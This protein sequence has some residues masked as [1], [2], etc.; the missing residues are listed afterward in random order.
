M[1]S[2]YND[3]IFKIQGDVIDSSHRSLNDFVCFLEQEYAIDKNNLSVFFDSENSFFLIISGASFLP[4]AVY[5]VDS[6]KLNSMRSSIYKSISDQLDDIEVLPILIDSEQFEAKELD[7]INKSYLRIHLP[8]YFKKSLDIK[9]ITIRLKQQFNNPTRN[10]FT[11]TPST[12]I[13][14]IN[15][16]L[17][18]SKTTNLLI[19]FFFAISPEN[20]PSLD[21]LKTCVILRTISATTNW[22]NEDEL[23]TLMAVCQHLDI[24]SYRWLCYKLHILNKLIHRSDKAFRNYSPRKCGIPMCNDLYAKYGCGCK[25]E[26][27]VTTPLALAFINTKTIDEFKF[28]KENGWL[29]AIQKHHRKNEALESKLQLSTAFDV[30]AEI[31]D[32]NQTHWG[33]QLFHSRTKPNT[34]EYRIVQDIIIKTDDILKNNFLKILAKYGIQIPN[35]GDPRTKQAI[36]KYIFNYA[37]VAYEAKAMK[38]IENPNEKFWTI[39]LTQKAGWNDESYASPIEKSILPNNINPNDAFEFYTPLFT[40]CFHNKFR[41]LNPYVKKGT[42]VDWKKEYLPEPVAIENLLVCG[43]SLF[44]LLL[45]K[46]NLSTCVF[47]IWG[48]NKAHRKR[49]THLASSV[50]G[51]PEKFI[52]KIDYLEE[53]FKNICLLHNDSL[54]CISEISE[55]SI[56]RYLRL[57]YQFAFE[58]LPFKTGDTTTKHVFLSSGEDPIPLPHAKKSGGHPIIINIKTDGIEPRGETSIAETPFGCL[59]T[60]LVL[61]ILFHPPPLPNPYELNYA[62]DFKKSMNSTFIKRNK[63][64]I[65]EIEKISFKILQTSMVIMEMPPTYNPGSNFTETYKIKLLDYFNQSLENRTKDEKSAV[66]SIKD[67][68]K[69]YGH[70]R[71]IN[72]NVLIA[73]RRSENNIDGFYIIIKDQMF[74]LILTECFDRL[75]C[76]YISK[77]RLAELLLEEKILKRGKNGAFSSTH[78]IK[79][80]RKSRRGYLLRLPSPP[81]TAKRIPRSKNDLAQILE[82][83]DYPLIF[84]F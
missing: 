3:L 73:D 80:L 4:Y 34:Q 75:F 45:K 47:H 30:T 40:F 44:P 53:N 21:N 32:E 56:Q 5:A 24:H 15:K 70:S 17:A 9:S 58:E 84:P 60:A 65:K 61:R 6:N 72:S 13:H 27:G 71:L 79:G 18:Q 41:L 16:D 67:Y 36:R 11:R 54:I 33:Y 82:I 52:Y 62:E 29:F 22:E 69:A 1:D 31:R 74:A 25:L 64:T 19:K 57:L 35:I 46:S 39:R 43:I 76:K 8:D 42:L 28:I 63:S 2:I 50:W 55:L 26:C 78:W 12:T 38:M 23:K 66:A 68:L 81:K 51:D 49:L 77:K 10:L 14:Y 7:G 37:S 48:G 20:K 83:S 59:A